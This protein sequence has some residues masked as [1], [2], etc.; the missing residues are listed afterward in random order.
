MEKNEYRLVSS[1]RLSGL[2]VSKGDILRETATSKTVR[3]LNV[4]ANKDGNQMLLVEYNSPSY[5]GIPFQKDI[6][7]FSFLS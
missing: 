6:N 2:Q 7:S 5:G 3:V 1:G 4:L